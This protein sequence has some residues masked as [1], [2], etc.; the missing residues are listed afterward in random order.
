ML[1]WGWDSL[2]L[3]KQFSAYAAAMQCMLARGTKFVFI[4]PCSTDSARTL[5]N[6]TR[7]TFIITIRFS[8]LRFASAHTLL[9][10]RYEHEIWCVC[11]GLSKYTEMIVLYAIFDNKNWFFSTAC[12]F[13]LNIGRS[14]RMR[15]HQ[16]HYGLF[17]T[18]TRHAI[19][20]E[21]A[22]EPCTNMWTTRGEADFNFLSIY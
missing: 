21:L 22:D 7:R 6:Q 5:L 16:I 11:E 8:R 14:V 3:P 19:D 12:G 2:L 13:Y 18:H 1:H 15:C 9:Y 4:S 20:Y 10:A 17:I